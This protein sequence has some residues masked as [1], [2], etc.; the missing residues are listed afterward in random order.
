M[1]KFYG[2][3]LRQSLAGG[4]RA[5]DPTRTPFEKTFKNLMFSRCPLWDSTGG[6]CPPQADLTVWMKT[7]PFLCTPY[8][9][10]LKSTFQAGPGA[11]VEWIKGTLYH[12]H[13][14]GVW[15]VRGG[16][17]PGSVGNPWLI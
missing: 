9:T 11:P 17:V 2:K 14:G 13:E 15:R 3:G 1:K 10:L 5:L 16:L 12:A 4:R 6:G 8:K 7:L